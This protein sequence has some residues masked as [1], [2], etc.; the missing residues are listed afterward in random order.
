MKKILIFIGVGLLVYGCV[1]KNFSNNI[2]PP[3][4]RPRA[5]EIHAKFFNRSGQ[6]N[7][8]KYRG[9][10]ILLNFWATWCPPC[11]MEIP[12]L[13]KLY[14]KYRPLGVR[15]IVLSVQFQE[16]RSQEYFENFIKKY[17][18]NFPV[19]LASPKTLMDYQ[20]NPIPTTFLIDKNGK[21]ALTMVGRQPL[22]QFEQGLNELLSE[23]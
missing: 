2:T 16:H 15:F 5:N 20:I 12:E 18:M 19:G 10:V 7:L 6:V 9:K 11:R 22:H 1:Q 3:D 8:A 14:K 17:S 23:K 21:I 4:Q 13:V